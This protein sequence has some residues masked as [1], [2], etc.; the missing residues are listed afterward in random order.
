MGD[1]KT[2]ERKSL[3]KNLKVLFFGTPQI[4]V[5]FLEWLHKNTTVVGVVCRPDEPVGRGYKITPPATK[6]FSESVSLP[7]FQPKGPWTDETTNALKALGADVGIIVAYGRI[8]PRSIFST[9][10]H[11]SL[12]IHFSL[13]PKYRG[14]APMQW[15][16]IKGE[17]KTG[18]TIF[19][20]EEGLDSGPV[21]IQAV[22]DIK[23]EDDIV[24]LRDRLVRI[25]VRTLEFLMEDIVSGKIARETQQGEPSLA[26]QL[27]KEDGFIA[28]DTPAQTIINLVRGVREWPG[29]VT[30]YTPAGTPSKQLKIFSAQLESATKSHPAPGVI[31][32]A[33][34]DGIVVAASP[35]QVR[36]TR[37][38][39]E[40]K[41]EMAAWDFWQGARLK[42]GEKL[43]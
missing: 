39:P 40:G 18:V 2:Q 16:L 28:W 8:L 26:P 14:A 33:N 17:E 3:V 12:N 15:S 1:P 4:A 13:L 7:V 22:T 41:K 34:K 38:Q 25:G 29:A 11:G 6:V 37:V 30:H 43:G 27:K 9:P 32:E 24:T 20:L 21:A 19:W 23:P 5:P 42:V 10:K 31:V 35:G 36:L